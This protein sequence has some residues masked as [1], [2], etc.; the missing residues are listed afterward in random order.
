M[1]NCFKKREAGM[2]KLF[3][4]QSIEA[5]KRGKK[6]EQQIQQIKEAVK[7]GLWLYAG[8]GIL[9]FGGAFGALAS[10]AGSSA[11]GVF[12]WIIALSGIFAAL[13]GLTTWNLRRKLLADKVQ[14]AEGTVV[15]TGS[16]KAETV[17]EKTLHPLGLAGVAPGFPPGDY[18]FYFLNT[19]NWLLSAE[20]LSTEDEMRNGLN[21]AL[22]VSLGYEAADLDDF[23]AR[24]QRGELKMLQGIPA[25]DYNVISGRENE[26]TRFE[27]FCTMNGV[28][29]PISGELNAAILNDISYRAYHRE[30]EKV[31]L[32]M[33][34][35]SG[36]G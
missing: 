14:S 11:A 35:I 25:L 12:S 16:Y 26:G 13:R 5:N 19:R 10:S 1:Y 3:D 8:L 29:F 4:T 31:L 18:R 7:P 32:A 30:G 22:A 23:R 36:E 34:V 6:S 33:E 17:E 9:V 2:K 20:P 28:K 15:F 24:A 27:Y 21:Q